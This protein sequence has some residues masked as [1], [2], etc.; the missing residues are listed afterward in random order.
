VE[1]TPSSL[2]GPGARLRGPRWH[3][4][5]KPGRFGELPHGSWR[6]IAKRTFD[7]YRADGIT[8]LAA[9]L[10]YRSVLSVFPG[11]IAVVALLGVFGQYPQTF[12]A[13]L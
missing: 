11:L 7:Q 13:V 6:R 2:Q 1:G 10:T 12:N 9:A 5:R 3:R 4:R 8:N